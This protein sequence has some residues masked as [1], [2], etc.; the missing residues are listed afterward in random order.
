[1]SK[2]NNESTRTVTETY[3]K[4]TIEISERHQWRRSGVFIANFEQIS[5]IALVISLL[6]LN[7]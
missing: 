3:L 4:L 2:V 1:M 7:K 6:T 5:H